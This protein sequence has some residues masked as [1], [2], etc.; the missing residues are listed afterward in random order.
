MH[1]TRALIYLLIY[2]FAPIDFSLFVLFV[3][4]ISLLYST[5]NLYK[6]RTNLH[7]FS[8]QMQP[9][10]FFFLHV[11]VLFRNS[12]F[13]S[14]FIIFQ[15]SGIWRASYFLKA[16]K[17]IKNKEKRNILREPNRIFVRKRLKTTER[18]N[19]NMAEWKKKI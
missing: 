13:F 10:H 3:N 9:K 14:K 1:T 18:L 5:I 2:L 19:T 7:F 11:F 8:I 6:K 4:K 12:L 15:I 17:T 16:H